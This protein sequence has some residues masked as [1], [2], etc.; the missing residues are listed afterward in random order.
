MFETLEDALRSGGR[1]VDRTGVESRECLAGVRMRRDVFDGEGARDAAR[2]SDGR[3]RSGAGGCIMID[4]PN[5]AVM[6]AASQ[7]SGIS[8]GAAADADS[9][10]AADAAGSSKDSVLSCSLI[11]A[12]IFWSVCA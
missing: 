9:P 11:E 7:G 6:M 10:P 4:H 8:K 1:G 2:D 3:G 5:K 12:T